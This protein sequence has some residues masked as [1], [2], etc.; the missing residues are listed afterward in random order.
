MSVLSILL[1]S[2]NAMQL[3]VTRYNITECRLKA[4]WGAATLDLTKQK[5][6]KADAVTVAHGR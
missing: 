6:T 3:T 5:L 1:W 2:I 4:A